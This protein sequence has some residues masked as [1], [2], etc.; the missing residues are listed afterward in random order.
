MATF[1]FEALKETLNRQPIDFKENGKHSENFGINVFSEN[2]MRQYLTKEAFNSVMDAM[3]HGS[4]IDRK[5]ADQVASSM[6]DWALTK[7]VTHYTHWFQP[8]TGG[9]AEKHDAFFETNRSDGR[10][11]RE[12]FWFR[13]LSFNKNQMLLAFQMEELEILL[14]PW[15]YRMGSNFSS[16]YLWVLPCVFLQCLFLYG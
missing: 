6:K 12:I 4:K 11:C 13:M 7:D 9:T 10:C 8:L 3:K 16:I 5:I 2:T 1:R 14:K 15:I